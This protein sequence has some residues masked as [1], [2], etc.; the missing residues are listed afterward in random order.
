VGHDD[1]EPGL[2]EA[3]AAGD[4]RAFARLVEP[5]RRELHLFCYR[6]LGSFD[7]A[8]D[9]LQEAQLKAWRSVG[10]FDGRASF[11]TWMFKVA[12][13]AA[14]DALRSRRRRVL[15]QDVAP[16][17]S[18]PQGLG[19]R[20]EDLP[21]LQPY[22]DALLPDADPHAALELRESV[23]LAFV[24]ALQVLP[25]QQRAAL[26]L[27]DVLG[28]SAAE[29]ARALATS[30]AAVNSALQRARATTSAV[31]TPARPASDAQQAEL[32]GRYARAWESGDLDAIVEMLTAD[33]VHAMP[34]WTAWFTGRETLRA[35][36]AS[37]E[38]WRGR[39]G[40]GLFRVLPA[41]LNGELAFAEYCREVREG[42]Y[43]ALAFT[44]ARLDGS[45][46]L[47][48]E[49]VSFV[50]PALFRAFGFPASLPGG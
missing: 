8:E 46:T 30:V 23:R 15:P 25:P 22:P 50:S 17:R 44:V 4:H 9:V 20:R 11:R 39:P 2:I 24:R 31:T 3:A 32:A 16:A 37:Y 7:D 18:A 40:P 26:V 12:A 19:E 43:A 48:T 6:M 34:P 42:P 47:M 35:L 49:K 5:M 27:R 1:A 36:Y 10:S 38:I 29:V 45:G 21:W 41:R 28:W 33:A 13:N 14:L